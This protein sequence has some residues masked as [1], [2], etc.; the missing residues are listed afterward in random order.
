MTTAFSFMKNKAVIATGLVGMAGG[1]GTAAA[2]SSCDI[3]CTE[4]AKPSVVVK[5]LAQDGD[6]LRPVR[7]DYLKY[8]VLA[9]EV[10]DGEDPENTVVNVPEMQ[11]AKCLNSTCTEWAA[12]FEQDG[13]FRIEG[14]FCGETYT[15]VATVDFDE[16]GCHVDT[17][18]VNIVV[19]PRD[20]T[21]PPDDLKTPEAGPECDLMARPSVFVYVA[22]QYDDYLAPAPVKELRWTHE[23]PATGP[24]AKLGGPGY[25]L[26][27]NAEDGCSTW[28]AGWEVAGNISVSTE[29]CDTIVSETVTVPMTED[30][31]HVE[32]QFVTLLVSTKGC[33]AGE[34]PPAP[35][36]PPQG[37]KDLK[38]LPD[39][40]GPQG[41]D[42]FTT[43]AGGSPHGPT[44]VTNRTP[45]P[46]PQPPDDVKDG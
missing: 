15:S 14:S 9:G 4:G 5:F 32:T 45:L 2:V 41:P 6:S 39:T 23:G 37:P 31:C 43:P 8:G 22:R 34:E 30:G 26:E 36:T 25:C 21:D 12:G 11:D 40:P 19:D 18:Y 29:W 3:V 16:D 46:P 10:P 28:T 1:L 13:T 35:P 24:R 20:C 7:A 42:D 44:D 33:I 27:G 38:A 17:E